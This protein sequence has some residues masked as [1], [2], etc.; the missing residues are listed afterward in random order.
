MG[1]N[2]KGGYFL[3]AHGP[4]A[5]ERSAR[6]SRGESQDTHGKERIGIKAV[7]CINDGGHDR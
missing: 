7:E 3:R 5:E 6:N 4:I 2:G 1:A